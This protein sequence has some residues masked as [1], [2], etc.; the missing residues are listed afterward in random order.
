MVITDGEP[1][2]SPEGFTAS[3]ERNVE[4]TT[5]YGTICLPFEVNS[6]SN[7]QYYYIDRIENGTL[8]L[9]EVAT[10]EAHRQRHHQRRTGQRYHQG[11]SGCIGNWTEVGGHVQEAIHH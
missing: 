11:W 4:A 6:D 8:C 3:Y 2:Y 1:F 9:T 5:K 10:L 7:V